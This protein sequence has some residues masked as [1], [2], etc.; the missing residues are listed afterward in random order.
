[1]RGS[2]LPSASMRLTASSGRPKV[3]AISSGVRPSLD[4][5][6]EGLPPGHL[7][8]V[9]PRDILDQRRLDGGGIVAVFED[10]A[11]Q[12]L[13]LAAFVAALLGDDSAAVKRR[14]PATIS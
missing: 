2:R 10:R 12:R 1:M 13:G 11:G 4:Q 9:E 6:G 3:A 7:V 8:G 14:A 5:P